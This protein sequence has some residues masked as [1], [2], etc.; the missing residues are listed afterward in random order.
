[1]R[2]PPPVPTVYKFTSHR[3]SWDNVTERQK[4]ARTARK[5]RNIMT[6]ATVEAAEAQSANGAE[7]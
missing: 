2:M 7:K 1:M 6:P 3:C 5:P 4:H